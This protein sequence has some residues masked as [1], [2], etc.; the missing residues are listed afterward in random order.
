MA[1]AATTA[2]LSIVCA[3]VVSLAGITPAAAHGAYHLPEVYCQQDFGTPTFGQSR[4]ATV[5][6]FQHRIQ[7]SRWEYFDSTV[8]FWNIETGRYDIVPR[9]GNNWVGPFRPGQSLNPDT[10][11]F[12]FR[13]SASTRPALPEGNYY[14]VVGYRWAW[15]P[16]STG[17][18]TNNYAWGWAGSYTTDN[19]YIGSIADV[20]SCNTHDALDVCL[21]CPLTARN[22]ARIET[23]GDLGDGR[24]FAGANSPSA[25]PEDVPLCANVEAT[26]IGTS[27]DDPSL[28]GTPGPD[29]IVGL[30]GDDI[31]RGGDGDDIICG[32]EGA[33]GLVG[34]S[35]ADRLLGDAGDDLI[36]GE[37]GADAAEGGFGIDMIMGG[38]GTDLLNGG[39]QPYDAV[40][41]LESAQGATIDLASGVANDGEVDSISGFSI[42]VG[43]PNDDRMFGAGGEQWFVPLSG[44]DVVSGGRGQDVLLYQLAESSVNV[45]LAAGTASGEGEDQLSGVEVVFGSPF[46][47]RIAGNNAVNWL[48]G[49][50][51]DDVL[52]GGRGGKDSLDGDGGI[53]ECV[54]G[55]A[56]TDCDNQ[57]EGHIQPAPHTSRPKPPTS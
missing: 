49:D 50:T 25:A 56:Y 26:V 43:S 18:W 11:E 19:D 12:E 21:D 47:D 48:F 7:P 6:G 44:N 29:V 45:D 15:G 51:G 38:L 30:G 16:S 10:Y 13:L 32:G 42:A 41:Y 34:D 3:T 39:G 14:V 28:L 24:D 22:A 31:I 35:G 17:P 9:W 57:G 53:D 40:A 20:R 33:D 1:R 23:L 52:S 46:D 27:G 2:A 8:G 54:Q 4:Q 55:F 37:A 5:T 36:R